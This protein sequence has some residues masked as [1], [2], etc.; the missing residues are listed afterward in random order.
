MMVYWGM[1]GG[2]GCFRVFGGG[3][4][5]LGQNHFFVCALSGARDVCVRRPD[6]GFYVVVQCLVGFEPVGAGADVDL[7][8]AL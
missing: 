5:I 1:G 7:D 6:C 2:G 4:I 8:G 3:K